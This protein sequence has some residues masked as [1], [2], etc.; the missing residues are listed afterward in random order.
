MHGNLRWA[1]LCVGLWSAVARSEGR[2]PL[3]V[4]DLD[5]RGANALQAEAATRGVVRGLRDLDVFQVLSAED[6]RQ[7][8]AIERTRQLTG[9][10]STGDG[11]A[12]LAAT[13]G[14]QHT[15]VGT[16]TRVGD[17]LEIEIRLLDSAS[18]KVVNQKTLSGTTVERAAP[19]LPGLAQELVGPLLR[20]EQGQL[21]VHA[22]EEG[23]EILVDDVLVSSTPQGKAVDVPRGLHRVQ[24][25]KDG[26]I[27]QTRQVRIEPKQLRLEDFILLPSPDYADAYRLR[28]ARLRVG[29]LLT[30][31]LAAATVATAIV[32]N[33]TLT[34][35]TYEKEFLP[36]QLWFTAQVKGSQAPPTLATGAYDAWT[37]CPADVAGCRSRAQTLQS[38]LTTQQTVE[39]ALLGVGVVS[40]GLSTYLWLSGKD[41]NR[42]VELV[43]DLGVGVSRDGA[44]FAFASRF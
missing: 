38:Q 21:L 43:S 1:L 33:R 44:T 34:E 41:P 35:P 36:R 6:V 27:A 8:L 26:F 12:T 17:K 30:T 22:R 10:K 14:A 15:V 28:H 13:L 24:V 25:R 19:T 20:E 11:L 3:L 23:A 4:L 31:G 29:A 40:A 32:L 16:V 7:L 5:A 37:K 9:A 42:Y 18:S 39:M 2:P